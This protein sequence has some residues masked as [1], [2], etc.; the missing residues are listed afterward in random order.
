M[1]MLVSNNLL[2]L[3][4]FIAM[5]NGY[6]I[7]PPQLHSKFRKCVAGTVLVSSIMGTSLP[8]ISFAEEAAPVTTA[9]VRSFKKFVKEDVN[10]EEE[11]KRAEQEAEKDAKVRFDILFDRPLLY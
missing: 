6:N 7:I 8:S 3:T 5:C 1:K 2:F 10:L 9:K 4:T 11:V